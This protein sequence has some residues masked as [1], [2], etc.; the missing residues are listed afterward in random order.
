VHI[1]FQEY[2]TCVML[3]YEYGEY[4]HYLELATE[5]DE[6]SSSKLV[7]CMSSSVYFC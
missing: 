5:S 4:I 3:R 7:T 6:W 2:V 1:F